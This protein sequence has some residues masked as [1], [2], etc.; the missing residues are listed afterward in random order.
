[1]GEHDE[2]PEERGR[3]PKK[4]EERDEGNK[5]NYSESGKPFYAI[6]ERSNNTAANSY[7]GYRTKMAELLKRPE[8][9]YQ[10]LV[11]SK[12]Q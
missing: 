1:M 2:L 12:K 5:T 7:K 8:L 4:K 6:K 9:N 3:L 10:N 11:K